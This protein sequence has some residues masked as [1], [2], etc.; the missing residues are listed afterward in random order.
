MKKSRLVL[1]TAL[2][3]ALC[4]PLYAADSVSPPAPKKTAIKNVPT[5]PCATQASKGSK[6]CMQ[7]A[8]TRPIRR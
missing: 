4:T 6:E 8:D 5:S 7:T 2:A 1:L 3:C